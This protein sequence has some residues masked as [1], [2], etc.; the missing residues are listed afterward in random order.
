LR[1]GSDLTGLQTITVPKLL[2]DNE[3]PMGDDIKFD[4]G[5]AKFDLGVEEMEGSSTVGFIA[6]VN[7]EN[8]L[9]NV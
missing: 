3:T 4:L 1:C 2:I 6:E 8:F 9:D 5:D 7:F